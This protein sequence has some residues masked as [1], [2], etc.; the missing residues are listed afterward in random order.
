MHLRLHANFVVLGLLLLSH[1]GRSDLGGA[2]DGRAL[3]TRIWSVR[4]GLGPTFNATSCTACHSLGRNMPTA[5]PPVWVSPDV[6]DPTGGHLFRLFAV[7]HDGTVRALI[8]PRGASQRRAPLLAGV[9]LLERYASRI[10][11][12][13]GTTRGLFGWK[14]RY[15]SLEL[16]IAGAL[17]GEMGVT[18]HLFPTD[19]SN[20]SQVDAVVEI[21]REELQLLVAFV[22]TTPPPVVRSFDATAI[23]GE[24]VFAQIGCAECHRSDAIESEL[25]PVRPY[26]DLLL[27]DMGEALEDSVAEPQA[28]KRQFRTPP[29]WGIGENRRAFLHD[30]RATTLDG[31]I[32][33]HAGEAGTTADV[34]QSLSERDQQAILAFLASL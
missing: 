13:G 1:A 8:P 24:R 18:S 20:R 17:A 32:R 10:H 16:A 12:A 4:D 29:L 11:G 9:G 21:S 7:R 25:G 6:V 31:A 33:A 2:A 34:Y 19:G 26:T 27:H 3:F 15:P 14:A 5:A 23:R 28:A 22:G 30:G